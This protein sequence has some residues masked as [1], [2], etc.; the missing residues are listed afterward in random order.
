MSWGVAARVGIGI[1]VKS[2]GGG[3]EDGRSGIGGV[4]KSLWAG[5]QAVCG[6][7]C[8]PAEGS[9]VEVEIARL[10]DSGM[11]SESELGLELGR[12]MMVLEVER[13]LL[14]KMCRREAISAHMRRRKHRC[15]SIAP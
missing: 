3:W 12:R 11:R 4:D 7:Y 1:N 14:A 10:L 15:K 13:G 8:G 6:G 2:D 9:D 5:G